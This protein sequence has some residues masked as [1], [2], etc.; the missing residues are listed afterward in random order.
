MNKKE[1]TVGDRNVLYHDWTDFMHFTKF[2]TYT[3]KM[4][5]FYYI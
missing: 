3:L 2:L 4:S 1:L 5:E